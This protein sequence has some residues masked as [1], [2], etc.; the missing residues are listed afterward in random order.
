[1][2]FH[3]NLHY[4]KSVFYHPVIEKIVSCFSNAFLVGGFVRDRLLNIFKEKVDLDI[5]TFDDLEKVRGCILERLK[6]SSFSFEKEKTV[7]TFVG[8]DFRLDVSNVKDS[9]EEDLL[10]RDFTINAIAV[11]L[12][13]FSLVDPAKGLEDLRKKLIRPIS[14]ESIQRDPV[15]IVRGVRFKHLLGF[16]Y[17]HTFIE[18]S[19]IFSKSIE[20]SPIE[21][22]KDEI[23]KISKPDLFSKALKDF[24]KLGVFVPIFKELE[25]LE[26]IPKSPPHDHN[27]LEH[28]FLTVEHL[29]NFCLK[30]KEFILLEF[31]KEIG[32]KELFKDF[33]DSDCLK[34]I[35][36]YHDVGKPITVKERNGRLTF[37]NHDKVGAEIAKGALLRLKFGKK[38]SSLAYNVVRHHLRPFFLYKLYKTKELS[39]KAIYRFFDSTVGF[40]FHVLLHSVADLMATSEEKRKESEEFIQFIHY[41]L[42]FYKERFE[43]LKPLLSGKEIM[44]IKGFESPNECIGKIK[45]KLFELQALGK[46]KTIDEAIKFVKGY[47]CENTSKS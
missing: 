19:R 9:L 41:I 17:H 46:I 34:L 20:K 39:E 32:S 45:K 13:D 35:A 8:K 5:I 21:R 3:Y 12:N 6:V 14:K 38:A 27:L 7:I 16:D 37:Y 25:D 43:N 33:S 26:K 22:V 44:E 15:R 10:N 29:E 30:E 47:T 23:V 24:Y 31:S 11:S 2:F 4:G 40:S 1:M 36:L 42:K 18:Y 28:T